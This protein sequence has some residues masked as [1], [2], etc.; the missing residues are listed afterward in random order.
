M[1]QDQELFQAV[2]AH[3]A[4]EERQ[5]Q[6]HPSVEDLL[7]YQR[8]E[9][10]GE[11]Q[12]RVQGHLAVCSMCAKVV[13]DAATFPDLVPDD[14]ES[15]LS[16]Q[17]IEDALRVLR[18]KLPEISPGRRWSGAFLAAAAALFLAVG[19]AGWIQLLLPEKPRLLKNIESQT[20]RGLERSESQLRFTPQVDVLYL[21][22]EEAA[23]GY[24]E[25]EIEIVDASGELRFRE[26]GFYPSDLDDITIGLPRGFL[27]PGTY[28]FKMYGKQPEASVFLAS[29]TLHIE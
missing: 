10:D 15:A 4:D 8:Q 11:T 16:E 27:A 6:E 21:T 25:I 26:A 2:V 13:L 28:D 7:A 9:L 17:E 19:A 23:A 14:A 24:D 29:Y 22:L 1:S 3:L 5:E 20:L 12:D 18:T